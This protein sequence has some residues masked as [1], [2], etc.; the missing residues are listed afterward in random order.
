MDNNALNAQE[1]ANILKIAKNTVYELVKRGELNSYKVGRKIR[2]TLNDVEEYISGSKSI[3]HKIIA[4]KDEV[5]GNNNIQVTPELNNR[6]FVICGQD[7]MLDILSSYVEQYTQGIPALRS[8]IGSYNSLT[9]L[10]QGSIQVASA[11]LWDGDTG[12]YNVPY[13]RRLVPGIPT[14]IIHLTC[15]MQGFYVKKGNPKNIKSWEDFRRPDI[16][17]I[18]REKGSG[19]RV[20][21]DEHLRLLGI[22]SSLINGYN[23]ENQSHLT[24][25]STIARGGADVAVGNEK[26]ASQVEGI[27]FIPLQK[28]RYDL[29]FKKEDINTPGIQAILQILRSDEFKMEFEGIG[30]YDISEIGNIVAEI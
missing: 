21:L 28:E 13:V 18:N 23:R 14:V 6:G 17:M 2:F 25:A 29:V 24:V 20:L 3:K 9:A 12:E 30:G 8:Y 7:L 26:I 10:Y 1:V 11:H 16:T 27:E 5:I 15:R 22:S 19:S 4:T